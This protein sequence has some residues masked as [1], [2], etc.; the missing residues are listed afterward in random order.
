MRTAR[1]KAEARRGAGR[2]LPQESASAA[3]FP[4][5]RGRRRGHCES[6][7]ASG[8]G[9]RR[10]EHH[11]SAPRPFGPRAASSRHLGRAEGTAAPPFWEG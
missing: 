2:H 11:G 4:R 7:A 5:E 10:A 3:I 9:A 6:A 8:P 1:R